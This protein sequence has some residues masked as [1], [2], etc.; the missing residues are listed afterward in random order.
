MVAKLTST[1]TWK[2]S[3]VEIDNTAALLGCPS[4][5][6]PESPS[7]RQVASSSVE[8][9]GCKGTLGFKLLTF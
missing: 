3:S 1:I 2:G 9:P 8:G 6:F 7:S 5:F 4:V